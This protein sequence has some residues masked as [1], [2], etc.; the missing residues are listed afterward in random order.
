M[1]GVYEIEDLVDV[2][3]RENSL[4][5]F[6]ATVPPEVRYVDYICVVSGRSYRHMLAIAQIV[7]KVYKIKCNQRDIIPKIE[8]ETSKEWLAMD[9]GT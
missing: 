3:K 7:R 2:L 4:N 8:G 6:V 9:L 1:T 5:I